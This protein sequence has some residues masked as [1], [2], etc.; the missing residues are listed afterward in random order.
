[1]HSS[2]RIYHCGRCFAQIIICTHCDHG[3]RYC[4]RGCRKIA[5]LA[6]LKR[7]AQK[8][9][10]TRA[11]RFN[12]A[13]R[14]QRFRQQAKQKVTHHGSIPL[15][16]H[17]VLKIPLIDAPMANY[18]IKNGTPCLCHHCGRECSPFLRYDFLQSSHFSQAL[19]RH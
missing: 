4:A 9:Q 10:N 18:P 12:N 2:S 11:G 16:S 8:Y 1:M 6:S 14:Q 19:R 3:H 5:R 13:A 7:A 15:I 17:A